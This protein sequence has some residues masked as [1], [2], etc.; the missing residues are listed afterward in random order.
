MNY[1]WIEDVLLSLNCDRKS[2]T[3]LLKLHIK[4]KITK[5]LSHRNVVSITT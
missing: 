3:V 5:N 2:T 1:F 4:L